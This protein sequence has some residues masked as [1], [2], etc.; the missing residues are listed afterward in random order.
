MEIQ[1]FSAGPYPDA[2]GGKRLRIKSEMACLLFL[3]FFA[4]QTAVSTQ[5][6]PGD[7]L[8]CQPNEGNSFLIV[9]GGAGV[10]TVDLD[11]YS[12]V[13]TATPPPPL[14]ITT[15]QGGTLT[16]SGTNGNYIYTPPTP[17][18][19]GLDT[20]PIGVTTSWNSTGGTGS[21]GLSRPGAAITDVV[22]LNVIPATTTLI[23][24]GVATLVPVPA[25]SIS[26]CGTQGNP[27]QGPPPGT[28]NGCITSIGKGLIGAVAPSHGT[29]STSGN[30]LRYTPNSGYTGP[31]TFTYQAFGINTDGS[32]ALNS[33]NVSVQVTVTAATPTGVPTL[34]AWGML[35]LCGLL[36]L[37]G[38]NS[39]V[40]TRAGLE[41]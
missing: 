38:M 27:A 28:I 32:N 16:R 24:P 35:L 4:I 10:F 19:T 20:F 6:N 39:V 9:N 15:T 22:T 36:L 2:P 18:F 37:F 31:D 26:G 14:T 3:F 34:G 12:N 30:T 41:G 11:C 17:D 8:F 25:G 40:R 21:G 23:V 7:P 29:L 13:I 5:A 33:G 1:H